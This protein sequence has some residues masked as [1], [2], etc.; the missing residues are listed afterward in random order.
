MFSA[1]FRYDGELIHIGALARTWTP[2]ARRA[3]RTAYP[4]RPSR[5]GTTQRAILTRAHRPHARRP[6]LDPEYAYHDVAK[7]ADYRSVLSVPMLRDG[8][9]IGTITVYRDVARP[10]PDAQIEL[11][12]TFADQAV[13]AI[14]NVRLFNE[15]EV[16]NRDLTEALEQQ[17]ATSEILRVISQSPTDVQPV[18]DTIATAALKLCGA[19][20]A[21]VYTLRRRAGPPGV[22]RANANSAIW[23]CADAVFPAA[24]RVAT[25]R[26]LRAILTRSVVAI[27]DVLEDTEYAIGAHASAAGFRS[28]LAVPLMRE[29]NAIGG[30]AVGRD[31]PGP[32]P[33]TQIALLQTFADQAVIA[34]E[35]VRLF[36]ELEVRNRDLTEALEQQTATSDILRVISQSQTDVQPVF[37]TIVR[38][39][40]YA[41]RRD[42]QRRLPLDGEMLSLAATAGM[43]TEER[44]AFRS[45]YPRRIGPDTVSGRAVLERRVVADS[46]PDRRSRVR[47]RHRVRASGARSGPGRAA[48]ARRR[49]DR[50]HRRLARARSG[51]FPKRRSRCC[52]RSPTRRSS[53]SKTCGC[54]RSS[55]RGRKR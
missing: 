27:P 6:R 7:A 26:S 3:F 15:L 32:F 28:V 52:R 40:R 2:K 39:V 47:V 48:D 29:G 10:F 45:G 33:D 12:K 49:G 20:S 1:L 34:I 54:S 36:K 22:A 18:F 51:R 5:G 11:L 30:I 44:A 21:N 53:R 42:V 17:T 46:R 16:R 38:S 37:D 8:E 35:N 23:R 55:R 43:T 50:R 14:E 13:I 41:V 4:C 9:P 25:P 24:A 19:C 31:E